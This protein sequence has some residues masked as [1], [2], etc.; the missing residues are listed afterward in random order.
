MRSRHAT[1]SPGRAAHSIGPDGSHALTLV[2]DQP[3]QAAQ[4]DRTRARDLM[5]IERVADSVRALKGAERI[6]CDVDGCLVSGN[7]VLPGADVFVSRFGEKLSLVT[8]NS[9]DSAVSLSRRLAETGLH[10]VAD[11]IFAAG[12]VA[13]AVLAHH[14]PSARVFALAN[15][16]LQSVCVHHGLVLSDT[17]PEFLLICRD[18]SLS[19]ERLEL[20]VRF[21]DEGV[22]V[23]LA[24]RDLSHPGEHGPAI[25]TGALFAV[26]SAITRPVVWKEIGKPVPTLIEAALTE[27][28]P[29]NAV[30]VGD[31]ADTDLAGAQAAGIPCILVGG[32][33]H[34]IAPDIGTLLAAEQK[35]AP[36]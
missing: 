35:T 7:R 17:N 9:T 30:F 26:L 6:L 24:N 5:K 1:V 18:T 20:A 22:P 19:F 34:A 33:P 12:E 4:S 13:V 10:V 11:Q 16:E 2:Q 25:E 23:V 15:P 28:E 14:K 3:D 27:T 8:N 32:G 31:N 29:G 36:S 21:A